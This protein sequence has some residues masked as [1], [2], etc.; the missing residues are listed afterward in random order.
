MRNKKLLKGFIGIALA[1]V[2]LFT[3]S[4]YV[5][6]AGAAKVK[7]IKFGSDCGYSGVCFMYCV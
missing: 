1:L 3:L 7:P 5:P 4:I 2:F 6:A